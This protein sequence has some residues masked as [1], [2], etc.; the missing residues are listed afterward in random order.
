MCLYTKTNQFTATTNAIYLL[1]AFHMLGALLCS[2][3][4]KHAILFA[5]FVV[6]GIDRSI[7]PWDATATTSSTYEKI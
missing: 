2:C 4:T 3:L 6:A 1:A 7:F 5:L